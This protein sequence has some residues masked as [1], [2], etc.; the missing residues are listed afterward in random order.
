MVKASKYGGYLTIVKPKETISDPALNQLANK[1]VEYISSSRSDATKSAYRSD[2]NT[3]S[4]W[5]EDRNLQPLPA[6]ASTVALYITWLAE[7]GR[8]PSTISRALTSISQAHKAARF[9]TPT[10]ALE[11]VEVFKGIRRKLGTAQKHAKPLVLSELK[12]VIDN[13]RPTFLGRRDAALLMLGWAG[14]LRRSEIVTVDRQDLEFVEEG[15]I[16]TIIK[17]K[18]DQESAGYKIGIPF[19]REE[20]YCP[21]TRVKHWIDLA[22]IR[23]GPLFFSIGTAGKKFHADVVNPV[24]ISARYVNS[25][26]KKRVEQAG[27]SPAG[28]SGHSLRAGFVTSAAKYKIPEHLIQLH[29]RHRSTKVLRG[30]IRIGKLFEEN[31]M[32]T[33]L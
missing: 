24:R 29:T 19:G 6:Q 22:D 12:K 15:M 5:S 32:A 10:R 25:I 31:P 16:L 7:Q 2:W 9:D 18:T 30:Y 1:A 26:I 28:Y 20:R 14:A 23:G 3:F 13:L 4:N 11:V 21:V 8:A 27:L 17:S 33:L